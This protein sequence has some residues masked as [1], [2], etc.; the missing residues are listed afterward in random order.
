MGEAD[1][2]DYAEIWKQAFEAKWDVEMEEKEHP[3]QCKHKERYTYYTD[4]YQVCLDCGLILHECVFEQ[5]AYLPNHRYKTVYQRL[6]HFNERLSQFLANEPPVPKEIV[7][8]VRAI[9]GGGTVTKTKIRA[10]LRQLKAPKYIERWVAIW[11]TITGE[12]APVI[13]SMDMEHMRS[14][15]VQIERAF[16]THKPANRKAMINYN[17]VFVRIL[18]TLN[19]PQYYRFF[20]QLKSKAKFKYIDGIWHDMCKWLNIPHLPFPHIKSLR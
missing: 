19:L 3:P 18:Q 2:V 7:A 8:Q 15:F 1:E 13:Q 12:P 20:P 4:G 6:H 10:A 11:C 16:M 9:I 17:F 14:M 5:N